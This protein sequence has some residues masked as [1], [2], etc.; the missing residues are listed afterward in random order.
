LAPDGCARTETPDKDLES[1]SEIAASLSASSSAFAF[2][3]ARS[4][5]LASYLYAQQAILINSSDPEFLFE[6]LCSLKTDMAALF[7][8]YLV[9]YTITS[10][11]PGDSITFT[12]DLYLTFLLNTLGYAKDTK[13]LN[14]F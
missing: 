8:K 2:A 5:A 10:L 1:S 12:R 11:F 6:Y 14:K 3:A 13:I 4:A 9:V 7:Q